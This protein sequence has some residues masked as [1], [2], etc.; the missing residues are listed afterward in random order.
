MLLL[1]GSLLTLPAAAQYEADFSHRRH[2]ASG[3]VCL[4][5]HAGAETS[6]KASDNLLPGVQICGQ[7]HGP[8]AIK[9]P[10]S[11]TVTKFNHKLHVGIPGLGSLIASA[12]RSGDY[13]G[14]SSDGLADQL[15]ASDECTACHRG[16]VASDKMSSAAFPQMADCLVCHSDIEPP[17]S[18]EKCHSTDA[19]LRPDS[20]SPEFLE[21]HSRPGALTQKQSCA[22]CHGRKF[23]CLGCH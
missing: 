16:L 3:A 4:D 21:S 2:L 18:C 10:S 13:L 11:L 17:F 19:A 20:H 23:T 9:Q 15:A 7:C 14:S 6:Q 12:I 5:C 1:A 22:V 8:G